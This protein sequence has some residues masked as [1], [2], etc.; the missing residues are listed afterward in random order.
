[1][2]P[3]HSATGLPVPCQLESSSPDAKGKTLGSAVRLAWVS[4]SAELNC[5]GTLRKF[6]NFS[7]P[8]FLTGEMGI[9]IILPSRGRRQAST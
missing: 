5:S 8:V 2:L 7:R 9:P 4:L 1:M 3:V 6:P